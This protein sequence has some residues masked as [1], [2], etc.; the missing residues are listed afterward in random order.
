[1]INE[2]DEEEMIQPLKDMMELLIENE[3][4]ESGSEDI[5]NED[6]KDEDKIRNEDIETENDVKDDGIP[7]PSI[8]M[9]PLLS[10]GP[11]LTSDHLI[12]DQSTR[13]SHANHHD[14][15]E[16]DDEEKK[17]ILAEENI[18]QLQESEKVQYKKNRQ[19]PSLI[20]PFIY[21]TVL[22]LIH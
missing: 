9:V 14:D 8:P 20:Y 10:N 19:N 17:A 16:S 13:E 15:E 5:E 11:E 22:L 4:I 1:M 2:N 7:S 3:K 12:H 21:R 6:I 18:V